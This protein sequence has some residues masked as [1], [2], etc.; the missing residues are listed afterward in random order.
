MGAPLALLSDS[1]I[2]LTG[3]IVGAILLIAVCL[4]EYITI[5]EPDGDSHTFRIASVK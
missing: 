5:T 4:G 2:W 3:F 1:S